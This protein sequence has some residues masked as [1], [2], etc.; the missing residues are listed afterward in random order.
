M[1]DAPPVCTQ[2]PCKRGTYDSTDFA[3]MR[4][5]GCPKGVH[6]PHPM[7]PIPATSYFFCP[8]HDREGDNG[9]ASPV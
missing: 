1:I 5:V 2:C 7:A 6:R 8:F 9:P 3:T 4:W